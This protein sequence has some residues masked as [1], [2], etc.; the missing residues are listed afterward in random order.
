MRNPESAE[1]AEASATPATTRARPAPRVPGQVVECGW[2]GAEVAVPARGRVPK[3]CSGTCRHRAWEQ[4]RAAASGRAAVT[5]VDRVVETVRTE[6]VVQHH[7]TTV[8]VAVHPASAH[9]WARLLEELAVGLD[10]GRVYNRDLPV[11]IPAANAL[12]D[13]LERRIQRR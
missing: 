4:A 11:L 9:E 13:A 12:I 8:P 6:T 5:V 2:C 3:W 7:R 10:T 1:P